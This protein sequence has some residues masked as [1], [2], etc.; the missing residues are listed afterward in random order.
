MRGVRPLG[1]PP[2]PKLPTLPLPVGPQLT[3]RPLRSSGVLT[4]RI[5]P[6]RIGCD[7][8]CTLTAAGTVQTGV[9]ADAHWRRARGEQAG[10]AQRA[11]GHLHHSGSGSVGSFAAGGLPSGP[12]AALAAHGGEG[13][14]GTRLLCVSVA[15]FRAL[16]AV[17]APRRSG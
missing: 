14:V 6:V 16:L 2:P 3:V 4:S 8:I 17:D 7:T 11:H 15:R 10:G 12:S 1:N 13:L 9:A 5:L